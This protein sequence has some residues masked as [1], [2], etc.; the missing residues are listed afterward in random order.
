MTGELFQMLAETSVL[1]HSIGD[2][3]GDAEAFVEAVSDTIS[4]PE[5]LS[6]RL[7]SLRSENVLNNLSPVAARARLSGYLI[8]AEL[9]STKPYWLGQQVAIAGSPSLAAAYAAALRTQGVE[10]R[11]HDAAPLTRAG[12]ARIYAALTE[13]A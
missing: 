12:L 3:D 13:T 11:V 8:G 2:R 4:R 7:F 1:R 5:K 6:Q 10:A 9:A